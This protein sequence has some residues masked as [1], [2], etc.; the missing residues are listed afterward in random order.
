[1]GRPKL[2]VKAKR[3][4]FTLTKEAQEIIDKQANKSKFVSEAIILKSNLAQ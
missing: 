1:M 2:T 4:N 3:N